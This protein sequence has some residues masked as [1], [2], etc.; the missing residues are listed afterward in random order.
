MEVALPSRATETFGAQPFVTRDDNS[1][2]PGV[3]ACLPPVRSADA[4]AHRC[5]G[6]AVAGL[7]RLGQPAVQNASAG[8]A[9]NRR[10]RRRRVQIAQF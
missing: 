10:M 1:R 9:D 7:P 8:L 5:A 6:G 4:F 3:M 2:N